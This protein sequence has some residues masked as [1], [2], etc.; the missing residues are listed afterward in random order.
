MNEKRPPR[1]NRITV[2]RSGRVATWRI[3][4]PPHNFMNREMV[5]ELGRLVASAEEDPAVGAVVITGSGEG[6]FVTHYD[7]DEI[8]AGTEAVGMQ[9]APGVAGAS[10]R[11]VGGLARVP[12]ARSLLARTPASGL[13]ELREIHDLFAR[14]GRSPVAFIAA[15]GGPATG[16][17]C[18]LALAC[19]VRYMAQGAG[20]IG[21]PEMTLGFPPGA[22]G[23]QRLSRLL[24]TGRAL[25]MMLEAR[26]LEPEDAEAIGLVNRVVAAEELDR[27]ASATAA[28]LARRSPDSIAALKHAVNEGAPAALATGLAIERK[29]FLAAASRPPA[30]RA[31]RAFAEEIEQAGASPWTDEVR[32]APWREGTAVDLLED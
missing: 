1:T 31:M 7:I 5:A 28:R 25:E 29:W 3:D 23:T 14:I 11:T 18:E 21:L 9:V 16:G 12:G 30:H 10:L 27:E 8:V 4:Y 15:I 26:T 17:G 13:V 24:G 20:R 32:F 6:L 19:D 22:G 2:E